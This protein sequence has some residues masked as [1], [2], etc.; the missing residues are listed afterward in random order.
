MTSAPAIPAAAGGDE[1]EET[2][3]RTDAFYRHHS[4]TDARICRGL[5]RD[6]AEAEDATQQVF[7]SAHRALLQGAGPRD[8]A[9]WLAT[10]AHRRA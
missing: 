9:A 2:R 8:P 4:R 1:I 10:I 7:L 5:L 6:R 3:E